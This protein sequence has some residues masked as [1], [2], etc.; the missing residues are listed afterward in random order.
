MDNTELHDL[1]VKFQ[2]TFPLE[3][4]ND[5]TLEQYS[6]LDRRSSFTYWVETKT[7]VLGSIKGGNSFKFGIY[8]YEKKPKGNSPNYKNDE[9]YAWVGKLGEDRNQAFKEI[10][11]RII[12]IANA[13]RNEDFDTIEK[14]N[15]LWSSYKWKIAFLYSNEKIVPIYNKEW[16]VNIANVLGGN[17]SFKSSISDIQKFL[18]SKRNGK[19]IHEYGREL[20]SL[21][22]GDTTKSDP[23]IWLYAP[24]DGASEWQRCIDTSTMCLGWDLIGS[25]NQFSTKEE[26]IKKLQEVE[27][28]DS[29]FPNDSLAIWDFLTNIKVGDT[30]IAK[31]GLYKILGYGIV[32][33]NYEFDEKQGSYPNLRKV[34]WLKKGEWE[35]P[36][37]LPQKTLTDITLTKLRDDIMAMFEKQTNPNPKVNHWWLVANPKYFSFS[38][39][40]IGETIDYTVKTENGNLRRHAI[41]FEN[42]KKGD[43]VIGYEAHPVKKIVSLLTVE[44]ESDG[45]T[46][47]FKKIEDLI[48]P[49]SWFNFKDI[50]DLK[51]MEFLRN[52]N[53]SF[54]KLTESEFAIIIDLIRQDNPEAEENPFKDKKKFEKY[55][56][57]EFLKDVFI[58]ETELIELI[59]LLK[60][61]QNIILQGAP[62]VGKTY[63]AKRLAYVM[64]GEK[65]PTRI[66]MVQFH[67]NFSYED[68]IMGYKPTQNGGFELIEGKFVEF[69]KK[70][71]ENPENSYFFIIDEINRGNLSKIF[72]ELLMLIEKGYR[73]HA[74][75]LAYNK[76]PFS[77]P[78]N[79][80]LIG[81]MN[82]A[83]RSLAIIDYALRRRFA[84]FT[85]KPA[86]NKSSFRNEISKSSDNRLQQIIKAIMELNEEIAKDDSLGEGFCIGHSYFCDPKNTD[87][88]IENIIKYEVCPMLDEYWFDNSEKAEDQKKKLMDLL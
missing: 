15:G 26:I 30:I 66:E 6:N 36:K 18:L 60:H 76:Q 57:E 88:W 69:C 23:K 42:A 61:K 40:E 62:G 13:A 45:E 28:K 7:K 20:W 78:R 83:D 10:K 47:F 75:K 29:K 68:F 58:S 65:D 3:K 17:F 48:L 82:T 73:D 72:G 11:A 14:E 44:R 21:R 9:K 67:Q 43:I 22:E 71:K 74:I 54:F 84:F 81:M 64:M 2:E 49:V 59:N 24:G 37:Q 86:F 4:L 50:P 52:R 51:E 70:A 34:K 32:E 5:I 63:T 41:N 39:I 31:K 55:S 79:L 87:D 25:Y 33:G 1:Y 35:A 85:M 56:N 46:I 53:G 38:D 27:K 77:V 19:D 80:Y 8:E 12:K 16:L